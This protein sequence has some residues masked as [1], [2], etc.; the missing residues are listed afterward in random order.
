MTRKR[1][2]E[3]RLLIGRTQGSLAKRFGVS[4]R[5]VQGWESG[6]TAIPDTAAELLEII[7][8]EIEPT[9]ERQPDEAA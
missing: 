4:L 3:L 6:S 8:G 7:A 9:I 1:F 2:K 5:T